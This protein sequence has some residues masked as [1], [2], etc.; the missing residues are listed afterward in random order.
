V[1]ADFDVE[2]AN[3]AVLEDLAFAY[4]DDLA[5][6][7]LFGR[8]VRMTMP[9]GERV[10]ASSRWMMT[11]SWRGRIFNLSAIATNSVWFVDS[12]RGCG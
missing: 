11:R 12:V 8:A 3:G 7:G 4:R 6:D 1:V 2:R 5:A 9:P 10:S